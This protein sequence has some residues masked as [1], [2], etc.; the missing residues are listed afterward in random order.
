MA[1]IN[2]SSLETTMKPSLL[3]N[4]NK[5]ALI[6]FR[7]VDYHGD[8]HIDLDDAVRMTLLEKQEKVLKGQLD[9]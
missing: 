8:P 4:I 5:P 9:F 3:W 7:R 2:I 1:Y 6:S